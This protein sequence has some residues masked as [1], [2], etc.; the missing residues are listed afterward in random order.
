[1]DQTPSVEHH[2]KE[3][4]FGSARIVAA[5][6]VISRVLGMVRDSAIGALGA[7]RLTDLFMTA[8]AIPNLFR[9]L[10]GEGALS[11]AFV[12]VFTDVAKR[13]G[14]DKA[15]VVL[16]NV[17]G[18]LAL[19]LLGLLV[20]GEVG[21]GLWWWLWPGGGDW[22]LLLQLI[23]IV[24]PFMVTVCL[25]ALGSAALNCK[26]HFAYPAFAPIILNV[27][28]IGVV[29]LIYGGGDGIT[30]QGAFLLS[31]SVG[32]AGVVQLIGV[33]WLLRSA[34]LASLPRLRPLLPATRRIAALMLPMMVPL[35]TLQIS[36]FFDR[37]YA[38]LMTSLAGAETL[39]VFGFSIARPLKAGVVVCLNDANRLYQFPLGVLAISLATV[40]FPLFARYARA[41][42]HVGLRAVTSR[43]LRLSLFLGI[44][45]GVGLWLLA[46]PI[47]LVVFGHGDF[48]DADVVRAADILRMY[49]IGM[50]AYFCNHILL[51]A[52]FAMQ[53][54][55]TPLRIAC[56]LVVLNIALV[57]VLVFP[58]G[59]RGFGVAT[60]ITASLNTILLVIV[61]RRRLGGVHL[62]EVLASAGKT[63]FA[64][65]LMAAAVAGVWHWLTLQLDG[66][67]VPWDLS[68]SKQVLCVMAA[69]AAGMATFYLAARVMGCRELSEL[70][71]RGEKPE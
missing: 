51:R 30:W 52:F 9:R 13:E 23:Q 63:V 54:T 34:G 61:L 35:S 8:F 28:M 60:A 58:L 67:P 33:W 12:P 14:W 6:T 36:A 45:A 68:F 70:M 16:A 27:F 59:G 44:P 1:M 53:D 4:F 50:G 55:K 18:W 17:A 24:L 48:T 37:F 40:V 42:D 21:L 2:E 46:E 56:G 22:R 29:L 64:A 69:V 49:A 10:F 38:L 66:H 71:R 20:I 11:A 43:A 57:V 25:L 41:D 7:R 39:T 62:G 26:G 3:H 15:R 5:L 31:A 47:V 32:A 19:V 65:A